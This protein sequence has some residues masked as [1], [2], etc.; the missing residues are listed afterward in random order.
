MIRVWEELPYHSAD[1]LTRQGMLSNFFSDCL[2]LLK[3]TAG[4]DKEL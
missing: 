1:F 2:C 4:Y 3:L